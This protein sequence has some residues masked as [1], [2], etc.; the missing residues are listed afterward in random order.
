MLSG[1]KTQDNYLV[2]GPPLKCNYR[3]TPIGIWL[4]MFNLKVVANQADI[5]KSSNHHAIV[6]TRG[7]PSPKAQAHWRDLNLRPL[8]KS[9]YTL[10][11]SYRNFKSSI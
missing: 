7:F 9:P 11:Q 3:D 1:Y 4:H 10:P 8:M 6:S 2:E 5:K